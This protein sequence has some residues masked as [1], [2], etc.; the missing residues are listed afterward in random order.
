MWEKV[1][2][3]FH[4]WSGDIVDQVLVLVRPCG[5]IVYKWPTQRIICLHE[6][7][8]LTSIQCHFFHWS[9]NILH[10]LRPSFS[11]SLKFFY[12]VFMPF[13]TFHTSHRKNSCFARLSRD[14]KPAQWR[15]LLTTMG[16]MLGSPALKVLYLGYKIAFQ[17][18]NICCRNR[19]WELSRVLSWCSYSVYISLAYKR[20]I[21]IYIH[22]YIH[23]VWTKEFAHFSI[24][25]VWSPSN[26]KVFITRTADGSFQ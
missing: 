18:K 13:S 23:T 25:N 3:I 5:L 19:W 7:A 14:I 8:P 10:C 9:T 24:W 12:L 20:D 17:W 15:Q 4:S 22:T 1:F 16:S 6:S 11:V 26:K 21:Q 2:H